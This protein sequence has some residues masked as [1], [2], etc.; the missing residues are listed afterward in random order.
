MHEPGLPRVLVMTMVRDEAEMLPRWLRHYAG[1]VGMENLIVL[2]DNTTDGSTDGLECTVHRLPPLPGD[3]FE[4]TR[5]DLLSGLAQGFLSVYDYAVFVDADEFLIPDP[6][7]YAGLPELLAA[8]PEADVVAPVALNV[9]HL[10]AVEGPLRADRPVLEQRRF[11]KFAPLMCKPAVKRIPAEWRFASHGIKA[12]YAIDPEL[13]MLHLKFA[14]RDAMRAVAAHRQ[15]L[16][17]LDG[18]GS[19]S[20][21]RQDVEAVLTVI[22]DSIAGVDLDNVPEFTPSPERLGTVVRKD[23]GYY[24]SGARWQ[25]GTLKHQPLRRV[26]A[27]FVGTI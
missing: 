14:D 11:A 15:A 13:Y 27:R 26:P 19:K 25:L 6:T 5:M 2:D 8:R 18:R 24:R 7:K 10:P 21:W 12:P 20:S 17:E 3:R 23:K 9:L 4:R 16:V 22:D 1:Q